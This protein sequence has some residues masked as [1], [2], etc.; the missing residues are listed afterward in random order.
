MPRKKKKKQQKKKLPQELLFIEN[1]DKKWHEKWSDGDDL[2]D[3]PHPHR[4]LLASGGRPNLRKT[5]TLKNIIL[6]QWPPFEKIYLVHCGG[7]LTKE[8]DEFNAVLLDDIPCAYD[9]ELFNVK[10][11][12]LLILEDLNF[13][14]M[15]KVQKKNLD[16]LYGYTSTHLS[17]SIYNTVQ[18]FFNIDPVFR[19]MS[20]VLILWRTRD[21]DS[22]ETLRRRAD[23]KKEDWK[24]IL[25]TY[26]KETFDSLWIDNTK[27]SIAPLRINGY[28]VVQINY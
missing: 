6:R 12:N 5:N 15:N 4:I 14:G 18:N 23:M 25:D 7:T 10:K 19:R 16:R 9:G 26:L 24:F 17:L 20:N 22:M 21:I 8:Y 3:F 28:D 1:A 13:K 27:K 2:L 11:K